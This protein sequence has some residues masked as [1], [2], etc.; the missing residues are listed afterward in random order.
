MGPNLAQFRPP[1][2][3]KTVNG[4]AANRVQ[5]L[6]EGLGSRRRPAKGPGS[7]VPGRPRIRDCPIYP[8]WYR[9]SEYLDS[10]RPS[11]VLV[12]VID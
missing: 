12:A 11:E 10:P 2:I 4:D 7:V 8:G 5:E 9:T 3:I 6:V 1:M